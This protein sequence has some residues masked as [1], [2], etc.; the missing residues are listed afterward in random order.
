MVQG[1]VAS[2]WGEGVVEVG[3]GSNSQLAQP[4]ALLLVS[5]QPSLSCRYS[6][7]RIMSPSADGMPCKI[8]DIDN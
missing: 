6:M 5:L 4:S 7:A 3:A 8:E 1:A 2:R